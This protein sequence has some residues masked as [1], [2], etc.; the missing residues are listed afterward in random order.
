MLLRE[1]GGLVRDLFT[2]IV[3]P[4]ARVPVQTLKPVALLP[5]DILRSSSL[6][7]SAQYAL[8]GRYV[9][10]SVSSA[11]QVQFVGELFALNATLWPALAYDHGLVFVYNST[12]NAN[13][14]QTTGAFDSWF[15][16]SRVSGDGAAAG[17]CQVDSPAPQVIRTRPALMLGNEAAGITTSYPLAN[18][19]TGASALVFS[20][21]FACL[22]E[23]SLGAPQT[24]LSVGGP[25][26]DTLAL[27]LVGA[28]SLQIAYNSVSA[29]VRQ[30]PGAYNTLTCSMF[31]LHT[32]VPKMQICINGT[33]VY[34]GGF[35]TLDDFDRP[36][37]FGGALTLTTVAASTISFVDICALAPD[38][39]TADV[40]R[41]KYLTYSPSLASYFSPTGLVFEPNTART[42]LVSTS[43][44]ASF[45]PASSPFA[46][47]SSNR[48]QLPPGQAFTSSWI[49]NHNALR[50]NLSV[51]V[52]V[53][54]TAAP[55]E[56]TIFEWRG[57]SIRL[58]VDQT[59]PTR[60]LVSLV[61]PTGPPSTVQLVNVVNGIDLQVVGSVNDSVNDQLCSACS[62]SLNA[63]GRSIGL[64]RE[65][66]DVPSSL[67][68][69][70]RAVAGSTNP[71][72]GFVS[73][74]RLEV[75]A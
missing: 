16:A 23:Y 1:N 21:T 29:V 11:T 46:L 39:P 26:F 45:A 73:V 56:S 14:Q 4:F 7:S 61:D 17:Y 66:A 33:E 52:L 19:R 32:S 44:F 31:D 53:N 22:N 30:R 59:D 69:C 51:Y 43:T 27:S 60:V 42:S 41:L 75:V 38:L 55:S 37:G 12:L 9:V 63:N 48:P 6:Q 54:S 57:L 2:N 68:V 28:N 20:C 36:Q 35:T 70:N 15:V 49:Q 3:N 58:R 65:S 24:F 72:I 25:P 8:F 10:R 5:F 47:D 74:R 62:L 34:A 40:A 13:L 71:A 67:V 64:V 18:N 50:V